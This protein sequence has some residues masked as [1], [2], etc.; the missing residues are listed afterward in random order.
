[1]PGRALSQ[2][3]NTV[4]YLTWRQILRRLWFRIYRPAPDLSPAPRR[5]KATG[6]WLSPICGKESLRGRWRFEFLNEERELSFP[7]DWNPS[8]VSRL[9][10]YN[11]HY[12]DDLK[13]CKAADRIGLHRDL[14]IRWVEDNPPSFGAGWEPYPTS[15]RLV[16]W[17]KWALAGNELPSAVD[18]SLAVQARWL[19]RRIEYHLLGNHLLANAKALI[20]A[21]TY[22]D[23]LE[24]ET[25][26]KIGE[27]ILQK[28]LPEQILPDGGHYELSPMYH[29]LVLEDLLDL[30]N[31]YG[32][33]EKQAPALWREAIERML[34]WSGMMRHPDG[35]I[36]FFNDAAIGIAP[37]PEELDRYA[38]SLGFDM[39][40]AVVNGCLP[41]SGYCR[42]KKNSAVLFM[43]CGAVG[44]DV[45]PGHAHAD[46]LSFELSIHGRR[47]FV[48]SGTS[49]Y[50]RG[51]ER[52]RQRGSAAHNT[53]VIDGI[54]SSEVWA[55]FRV[56]RRARVIG[57]TSDFS[58]ARFLVSAV[59]DGYKRLPGDV[60]H[61]RTWHFDE[62]G[63]EIVD[64]LSG[65]GRHRV[66]LYFHLHPSVDVQEDHGVVHLSWRGSGRKVATMR[67]D[68]MVEVSV[69]KS[70]YH[71]EFGKTIPSRRI[72]CRTESK[73]PCL[74]TTRLEWVPS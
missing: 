55:A 48:N 34:V 74:L 7:G 8:G 32:A 14:L 52:E 26:K 45:Q 18:H 20:F 29:L 47:L 39:D 2:Y 23:G 28:Q 5:R 27:E 21:G 12:F 64:S 61:E 42:M 50:E 63:L 43:D 31:L 51:G 66:E 60:L 41:N 53:L 6:D 54:D 4:R 58:G 25:W 71:P 3:F 57:R 11:L 30:V 22:F 67:C 17:V 36:P 15:L 13:S 44:P 73:L 37:P 38:A 19:C 1:M 35:E 65:L 72:V 56:A 59:H 24:A 70:T 10:V 49:T 40:R 68:A 33:Y 16:N 9:W 46:T 62:K 69:E